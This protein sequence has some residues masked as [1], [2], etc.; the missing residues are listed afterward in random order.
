MGKVLALERPGPCRVELD[1]RAQ[2]AFSPRRAAGE[3]TV[4]QLR[5][6]R[7]LAVPRACSWVFCFS[8]F[9][10]GPMFPSYYM[11]RDLGLLTRQSTVSGLHYPEWA[12]RH[13]AQ[14][15]RTLR[16][17]SVAPFP[18]RDVETA[19][20]LSPAAPRMRLNLV[21]ASRLWS[22]LREPKH[23]IPQGRAPESPG[24]SDWE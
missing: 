24:V 11:S 2:S 4:S 9:L 7:L 14:A 3:N 22:E 17:F 19:L 1:G 6:L 18:P 13:L 10:S 8:S 15:R 21:A 23:L 20:F 12:S 16:E 5:L